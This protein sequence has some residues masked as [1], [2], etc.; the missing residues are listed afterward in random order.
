[1]NTAYTA[2]AYVVHGNWS[3]EHRKH[4]AFAFLEAFCK[5]FYDAGKRK[6]GEFI[7]WVADDYS[8]TM[9]TAEHVSNSKEEAW[10]HHDAFYSKP[11]AAHT[12]TPS[13]IIAI[14]KSDG[15]DVYSHT[16]LYLNL[17]GT[18]A[19]E[20]KKV[21]NDD[22]GLE[23]DMVLPAF[24]IFDLVKDPAGKHHGIKIRHTK[25][26]LDAGSVDQALARRGVK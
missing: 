14:E 23:Y 8:N 20:E 21:R 24:Y 3:P 5:K 10:D 2:P 16:L 12:H 25:T 11:L 18:P 26:V 15:W 22:D 19:S 4:P 6:E 1:M 7:D 9:H 17:E 13:T